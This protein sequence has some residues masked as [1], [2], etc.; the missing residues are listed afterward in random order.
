[1]CQLAMIP[2]TTEAILIANYPSIEF[3]LGGTADLH[4]LV[5]KH[6]GAS[7]VKGAYLRNHG[8]VTMGKSLREAVD[9]TYMVEHTC[10][11]QIVVRLLGGSPTLVPQ[12]AV[13]RIG[14]YVAML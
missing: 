9:W 5:L 8:L 4:A 2:I 1:M 11:M 13:D 7:S 3:H 10:R 14:Q 12:D 6:C